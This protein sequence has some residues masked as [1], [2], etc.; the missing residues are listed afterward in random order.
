MKL[1]VYTVNMN[2]AGAATVLSEIETI[3]RGYIAEK[4]LRRLIKIK[5]GK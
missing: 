4:G 5:G 1:E 3:V 2:N